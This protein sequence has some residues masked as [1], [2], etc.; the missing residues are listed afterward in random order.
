MATWDNLPITIALPLALAAALMSGNAEARREVSE[1]I[2][3]AL[4][5]Q[6]VDLGG[7]PG[8]F[9]GIAQEPVWPQPAPPQ[10]FLQ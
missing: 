7:D 10:S 9:L 8:Y 3:E 6:P 4:V 1:F 5:P 2:A